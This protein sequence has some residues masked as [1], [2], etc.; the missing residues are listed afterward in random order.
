MN[1]HVSR[2]RST[3]TPLFT[4]LGLGTDADF[5]AD[6]L[7]L[8]H[9]LT[10]GDSFFA[11]EVEG[12]PLG[13]EAFVLDATLPAD[14]IIIWSGQPAAEGESGSFR[15]SPIT[16]GPD[17][18]GAFNAYCDEVLPQVAD[19]GKRLIFR[20]HARHVLCDAFRIRTFLEEREAEPA[21]IALDAPLM[22]E[23]EMLAEAEDHLRR[24]LDLLAPRADAVF[25]HNVEIAEVDGD[26]RL[27]P[28]GLHDGRLD[29]DLLLR[30]WDAAVPEEVP[31]ILSGASL[32]QQLALASASR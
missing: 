21:G 28:A 30:L 5:A 26:S 10:P 22:L 12:D 29:P 4:A 11:C 27:T 15:R 25:L 31:V 9:P 13:D 24:A 16:W 7:V 1:L 18:L 14:R 32:D 6:A 19:A 20:P 8:P 3:L 17:A 23:P 2:P